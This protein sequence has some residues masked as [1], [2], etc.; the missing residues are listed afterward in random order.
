MTR[1]RAISD[2]ITRAAEGEVLMI[3][4]GLPRADAEQRARQVFESANEI[5]AR[6]RGLPDTGKRAAAATR[7]RTWA[8]VLRHMDATGE[9]HFCGSPRDST[10]PALVQAVWAAWG[11]L[12][13]LTCWLNV[14]ACVRAFRDVLGADPI[15][16]YEPPEQ[17]D[18]G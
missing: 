17:A 8:K 11:W 9:S 18:E 10:P 3:A 16:F 15:T 2:S 5:R 12:G 13:R 1:P 7:A 14:P 4:D 6:Y